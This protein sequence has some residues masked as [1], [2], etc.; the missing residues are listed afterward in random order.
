MSNSTPPVTHAWPSLVLIAFVILTVVIVT[1]KKQPE[2]NEHWVSGWQSAPSFSLPRRALTA[3]SSGKHLYV[4]GGVDGAGNYALD[5]EYAEIHTDGTLGPWQKTTPLAEGRFYLAS[6]IVDRNLYVIGGGLGPVGDDNQPTARIERA[7]ILPDGS[8]GSWQTMPS[9]QL[10]R[11]GLKVAVVD[12]K[13]YAIGGYSGVFLKSTEYTSVNPDGSF[14]GW[15]L[16]P[17]ESHLDRYI[18]S[19]ASHKG[20]LYLLG[21]HVQNSSEISYGDVESSLIQENGGLNA[22]EIEPSKLLQA[23]FIASSF[24]LKDWL[25][26]LGGHN[27]GTRLKSVEFARV[28]PNGRLDNWGTTSPLNTPRSAAATVVSGQ[29]A[30][31]LG[32]MGDGDALNS[33]EMATAGRNGQLGYISK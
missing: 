10:P 6:A 7:S 30:Y 26:V 5:S 28:F 15:I 21:G 31:V 13:I 23:R 1:G 22:W 24:A 19:V 9:M 2:F 32:G 11:R 3:V 4:I 18:H 25:Y 8:L 16:D 12:N 27:G 14:S 29:Y 20:R 17:Q 33:V